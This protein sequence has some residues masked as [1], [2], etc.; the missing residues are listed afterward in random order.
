[1]RQFKPISQRKRLCSRLCMLFFHP[2]SISIFPCR[3]DN[4]LLIRCLIRRSYHLCLPTRHHCFLTLWKC[5]GVDSGVFARMKL[6]FLLERLWLESV[7]LDGHVLSLRCARHE[8]VGGRKGSWWNRHC[9]YCHVLHFVS[10]VGRARV[11]DEWYACITTA[12]MM[13]MMNW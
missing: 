10:H 6:Q 13:L 1:M 3:L 8:L 2:M 7:M 5:F 12:V 4:M 11:T 9:R